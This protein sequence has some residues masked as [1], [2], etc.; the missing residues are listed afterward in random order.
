[1]T[2]SGW[3]WVLGAVCLMASGCDDVE[4]RAD[5]SGFGRGDEVVTRTASY[6]IGEHLEEVSYEVVDGYAV[7]QSDIILGRAEEIETAEEDQ[8]VQYSAVAP[9]RA[10]KDGIVP[11]EI[12]PKISEGAREAFLEALEDVHDL[13]NVSFVEHT[14]E[15]DFVMVTSH[16]EGCRAHLGHQ[17]MG[18]QILN[19]GPG[20]EHKGIALH[21]IGHALGLFHEQ[22]R[23]DRDEHIE[24]DWDMIREGKDGQFDKYTATGRNGEDV[25]PYD[26][27]SVMHYGPT[28]FGIDRAVTIRAKNGRTDFGQRERYSEGDLRGLERLYPPCEVALASGRHLTRGQ[29][30]WSCNGRYALTLTEEGD[31]ALQSSSRVYASA[32]VRGGSFMAMTGLGS[33]IVFGE[34]GQP[35]WTVKTKTPGAQLELDDTGN[36]RVVSPTGQVLWDADVAQE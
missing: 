15:A 14:D 22:S 33:L 8:D 18:Q 10:W 20:C 36:L 29:S 9:D 27:D 32:G 30:R 4:G 17:R 31:L 13:T 2:K 11:F 21:E 7:H 34:W 25:G 3:S 16:L 35:L 23:A 26:L 1:M 5:P 12:D 19:L 28:A 24:I 6:Y